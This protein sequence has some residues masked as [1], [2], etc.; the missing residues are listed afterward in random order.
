[1][2]E[3]RMTAQQRL[4]MRERTAAMRMSLESLEQFCGEC[5]ELLLT[6]KKRGFPLCGECAREAKEE[7][8]YF[9]RKPFIAKPDFVGTTV[10]ERARE[11]LVRLFRLAR[12]RGRELMDYEI[13]GESRILK[14]RGLKEEIKQVRERLD[15]WGKRGWLVNWA[16]DPY[17]R[18]HYVF[19]GSRSSKKAFVKNGPSIW[20]GARHGQDDS[21]RMD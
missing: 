2:G 4:Q 12:V 19:G 9:G 6:R 1:M 7:F 8:Q 11:F 20:K 10:D 13:R 5:G 21:N 3:Q 17:S 14:L 18:R 16:L 15:L